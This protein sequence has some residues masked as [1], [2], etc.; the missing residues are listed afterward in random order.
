MPRISC[1]R[2]TLGARC[3]ARRREVFSAGLDLA[4]ST[5]MIAKTDGCIGSLRAQAAV[6]RSLLDEVER[7]APANAPVV[8]REQLVEELAR[9]GCRFIEAASGLAEVV[10]EQERKCA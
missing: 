5:A 10:D 2:A 7:V 1:A 3:G 9:L 4:R 8:A 6:I